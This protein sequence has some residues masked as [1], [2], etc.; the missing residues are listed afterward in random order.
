MSEL[1]YDVSNEDQLEKSLWEKHKVTIINSD[2]TAKIFESFFSNYFFNNSQAKGNYKFYSLQHVFHPYA[3]ISFLYKSDIYK[4]LL[5]KVLRGNHSVAFV[6]SIENFKLLRFCQC[7]LG[8]VSYLQHHGSDD[9]DTDQSLS[10]FVVGQAEL[11][12]AQI[13]INE[14]PD[15][16]PIPFI[17]GASENS[18][19]LQV[20]VWTFYWSVK[21][22]PDAPFWSGETSPKKEQDP[23]YEEDPGGDLYPTDIA[24]R[25]RI[26]NGKAESEGDY[27]RDGMGNLHSFAYK[28]TDKS[29]IAVWPHGEKELMT[30]L[31]SA[32][33][34][35]NYYKKKASK[36]VASSNP[37]GGIEE[38]S[39]T[40]NNKQ[41]IKIS[42]EACDKMLV[43][44]KV[45]GEFK[46]P[47][48]NLKKGPLRFLAFLAGDRQGYCFAFKDAKG[49]KNPKS[50]LLIKDIPAEQPTE[51]TKVIDLAMLF[52]PDGNSFVKSITSALP[53]MCSPFL[54]FSDG[55]D[56]PED[57]YNLIQKFKQEKLA[58]Q[59]FEKEAHY[60]TIKHNGELLNNVKLRKHIIFDITLSAEFKAALVNLSL[61]ELSDRKTV[62]DFIIKAYATIPTPA[63]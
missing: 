47:R 37:V 54:A 40:D 36:T 43:T 55:M 60:P 57:N 48:L 28:I 63:L 14:S 22:Q 7:F 29:W 17:I 34:T 30:T 27:I 18:S 56:M 16:L 5:K 61:N 19:K 33:E 51:G 50:V 42:F 39:T 21:F 38:H 32:D 20:P 23:S 46:K 4:E 45:N 2:Y 41:V 15:E 49:R 1:I 9:C 25:K 6:L 13:I 3:G 58:D 44:Y 52:K 8:A 10:D 24:I 35:E 62:L 12:R 11:P 31:C 59:I 26:Q 53:E